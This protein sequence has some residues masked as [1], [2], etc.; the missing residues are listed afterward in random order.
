MDIHNKP[1]ELPLL[2]S[3]TSHALW[4]CFQ[5]LCANSRHYHQDLSGDLNLQTASPCIFL[6]S[7]LNK[8]YFGILAVLWVH[9]AS[10]VHLAGIILTH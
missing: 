8:S 1:Q 5:T 4:I 6:S 3:R 9:H 2:P 7:A 10:S